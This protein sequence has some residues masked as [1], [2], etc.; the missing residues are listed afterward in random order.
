MVLKPQDIYVVLKLV[1]AGHEPWSYSR[2]GLDLGMSPS[3]VHGA[4]K[5]APRAGLA[6]QG[7][8]TDR[9]NVR[10]LGEFSLHGIRY[11]SVPEWGN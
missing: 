8:N 7:D 5:R 9:P 4:L 11:V 3:E 10:R 1:V 2:L 6:V